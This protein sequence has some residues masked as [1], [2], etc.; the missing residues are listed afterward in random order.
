MLILAIYNYYVFTHHTQGA[1]PYPKQKK[2]KHQVQ[3]LRILA[4]SQSILLHNIWYAWNKQLKQKIY[5]IKILICGKFMNP[6]FYR[7]EI[8]HTSFISMYSCIFFISDPHITNRDF[9]RQTQK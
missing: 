6:L 5:D 2:K 1:K 7:A 4:R 3:I 9:Q 8:C